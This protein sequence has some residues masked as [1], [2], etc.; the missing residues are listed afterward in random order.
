M[1]P[2]LHI[3][4]SVLILVLFV[5]GNFANGFI[6]LVNFIDWVKRK[7]ISLADQILTALAVSRVGLLWA[8]LLNWYLTELNPAFY[9]VE[10]RITSYNAW[11]VTNHFS[12]WLAA[13]LSIFYLLKIANFSNLSFLNLKRRVRS[14]ILVILLGSLLFLVCHLLAVNMDENMWTE[15]YEGNMTG[16]MKLRNAAHLS[17]M[18]VTTLW[19]FIPFMLSLISFLMLIFSLCKHLKKMQLHGEGSRDPSTTVHIKALQTLI[20]FLLLCAIFFLFL[21]ISV[22][23]PR[24]LQNE[25]VFMVCKAVGNIYLSFDSFVLIWRTKKLKHI[26][27]LILCQIRC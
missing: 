9:S 4:F 15:E 19:S 10:L 11:V 22:W 17:Y 27:L 18:T 2:F 8:L 12:M 23:S 6:A 13:S 3:F 16:K 5:L 24:R 7:K 20:S 26:F 25:P 1:I 14:I 21:I